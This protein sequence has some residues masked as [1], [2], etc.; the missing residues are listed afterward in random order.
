MTFPYVVTRVWSLRSPGSRVT[1]RSVRGYGRHR[2]SRHQ[3]SPNPPPLLLLPQKNLPHSTL[4][5]PNA[6]NPGPCLPNLCLTE[7]ERPGSVIRWSETRRLSPENR[8]VTEERTL[9]GSGHSVPSLG[10][11]RLHMHIVNTDTGIRACR[12]PHS[13][14]HEGSHFYPVFIYHR[15]IFRLRCGV[16][17]CCR[18]TV[19]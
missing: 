15:F 3:S 18:R 17:G 10:S 16:V 8:A 7:P 5:N 6:E 11:T 9:G 4:Q 2:R 12:W 14:V 13:W 19:G 1:Q